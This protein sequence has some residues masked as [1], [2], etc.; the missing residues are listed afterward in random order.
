MVRIATI[1][2]VTAFLLDAS[3]DAFWDVH[4]FP[5]LAELRATRF[6][7]IP[8]PSR[9]DLLRRL[10]KGPPRKMWPRNANPQLVS[11]ARALWS[12]RE[13]KRLKLA[14]WELDPRDEALLSE[15][16]EQSEA[17]A[18]M[19]RVDDG[20]P[21][22]Y[23]ARWMAPTPDNRY[24]FLQGA[25]RLRALESALSSPREHHWF[26][27]NS[28]GASDWL[29]DAAHLEAVLTDFESLH[30]DIDEY[31]NVW[32]AFGWHHEPVPPG[33]SDAEANAKRVLAL[34]V[35]LQAGT[36]E[37]AIEGICQ[38]VSAW[39][40]TIGCASQLQPIWTR[41]WRLAVHAT[42][43]RGET[44]PS[45]AI[46]TVQ[47]SEEDRA[48]DTLNPPVGKL[49]H[50]FLLLCSDA[51]K[52][53][54]QDVSLAAMRDEAVQATGQSGLIAMHHFVEHL[55]YFLG[56]DRAWARS[57]LL[58]PLRE[59]SSAAVVL[60]QAVAR[61]GLG[62]QALEV[63]RE[64]VPAR[65]TDPR[66]N[67]EA[68]GGL[69][70]SVVAETLRSLNGGGEPA[71]PRST[72]MQMLRSLDDEVRAQAAQ[73][74][75]RFAGEAVSPTDSSED[76]FARAVEP[77]VLTCWPQERSLSTPGISRAFATLPGLSGSKFADAVDS[78]E[79]FLV[80]FNC[81][82]LSEYKLTRERDGTLE[83]PH[84]NTA[85]SADAALRLLDLTIGGADNTVVPTDLGFALGRIGELNPKLI[86]TAPFRR[87][88]ALT[89][90]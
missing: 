54:F 13:L 16:S 12:A 43:S 68:R 39:A 24:N 49:M 75:K 81:W 27:A 55:S 71:I 8:E 20:L 70:F 83:L 4:D 26:D 22:Q 64:D 45:P 33:S 52:K 50:A 73:T 29:R 36:L 42:N 15:Q 51:D 85:L 84:V 6:A 5:E 10:R 58:E 67:R 18:T 34:L 82:S 89:R 3:D 65:A 11:E 79:R 86:D 66:L 90:R 57:H 47:T 88:V 25:E 76:V 78:V 19:G 74:V 60:W 87:L 77:F 14:G 41:L 21:Q 1:D 9:A 63:L 28:S 56:A 31:P 35:R 46:S 61:R 48:L 23:A 72:V 40:R 59:D 69:V 53:P 2:E 38:W 32:D 30:V 7:S 80:P 44:A 62:R 37:N 17:L